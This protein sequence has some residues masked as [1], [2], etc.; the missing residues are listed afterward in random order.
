MSRSATKPGLPEKSCMARYVL[1]RSATPDGMRDAQ[2]IRR[3][4]DS[5]HAPSA[6]PQ[7][8]VARTG[9]LSEGLPSSS[10]AISQ[11][12]PRG[13]NWVGFGPGCP[14]HPRSLT[15]PAARWAAFAHLGIA[16]TAMEPVD[17][18]NFGC[19]FAEVFCFKVLHDRLSS[20]LPRPPCCPT[21]QKTN[22]VGP[23]NTVGQ[24]IQPWTKI[25]QFG[26]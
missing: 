20:R 5:R 26:S 3:C 15:R 6:W 17:P 23:N 19:E 11:F 7:S 8:T 14:I 16:G 22:S 18:L 9:P 1:V 24:D 10:A 12:S 13:D 4:R 25:A 21:L 2:W